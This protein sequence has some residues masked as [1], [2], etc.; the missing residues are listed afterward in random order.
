[1]APAK[2]GNARPLTSFSVMKMWRAAIFSAAKSLAGIVRSER[3]AIDAAVEHPEP[4]ERRLRS[5]SVSLLERFGDGF[6]RRISLQPDV[7][8]FGEQ[9]L[10]ALHKLRI[11]AR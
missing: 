4:D 1:M 3:P 6:G 8:Q 5:Q 11:D 10:P 7:E 9:R 2:S